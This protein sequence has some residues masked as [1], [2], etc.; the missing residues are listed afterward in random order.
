MFYLIYIHTFVY[1]LPFC[2]L[3]FGSYFCFSQIPTLF[4]GLLF[5]IHLRYLSLLFLLPVLYFLAASRSFIGLLFSA[6]F[7]YL[8]LSLSLPILLYD[9]LFFFSLYL[10]LLSLAFSLVRFCYVFLLFRFSQFLWYDCYIF[11]STLPRTFSTGLLLAVHL[12]ILFFLS[13]FLFLFVDFFLLSPLL[14]LLFC[15]IYCSWPSPC[16]APA[17][18]HLLY[19]YGLL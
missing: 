15:V 17:F 2:S 9:S 10:A 5:T 8:S 3:Y 6:H 4:I 1:R 11:L 7:R 12:R 13:H 18:P 19:L 16:C 14:L